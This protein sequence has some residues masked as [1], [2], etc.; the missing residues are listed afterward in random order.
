[1]DQSGTLYLA[2]SYGFLRSRDNAGTFAAPPLIVPGGNAVPVIAAAIDPRDRRSI[3]VSTASQIYRSR[4]DGATWS[5]LPAPSA[6]RAAEI[7]FDPAAPDALYAV[8]AP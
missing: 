5:I 6:L 7:A 4:D 3:V 8:F 2:S 1:M